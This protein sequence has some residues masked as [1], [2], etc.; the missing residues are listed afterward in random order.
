MRRFFCLFGAV[1]VLAWA[2]AAW[3]VTQKTDLTITDKSGTPVK[4][5]EVTLTLHEKPKPHTG[6]KAEKPRQISQ[7]KTKTDDNGKVVLPYEDGDLEGGAQ[8]DV[9]TKTEHG[10][11]YVTDLPLEQIVKTGRAQLDHSTATATAATPSTPSTSSSRT[12]RTAVTHVTPAPTPAWQMPTGIMP[13]TVLYVGGD[14]AV[15]TTWNN[16]DDFPAFSSGGVGGGGHFGVRQYF[17]QNFFAGFEAGWI[18]TDIRGVNPDHAFVNYDWQAVQMGQAGVTWTPQQSSSP[19]TVYGGLGVTE[20]GIRL[21]V[22]AGAFHEEMSKTL[23]GIVGRAGVEINFRP[24]MW[25]GAA[26]QYSQFNGTVSDSSVK[27]QIHMLLLTFSYAI[28][29]GF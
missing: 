9:E 1:C 5:Q 17:Y 12:E 7:I 27:T 18:G 4:N 6:K 21:G 23:I 19:I 3:A 25:L 8:L 20:G 11:Q 2:S 28:T 22:D 24:N 26:Y 16:Y 15:A 10:T 13:S 29:P 14:F